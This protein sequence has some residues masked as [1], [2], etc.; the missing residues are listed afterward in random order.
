MIR[1][2]FM[3]ICM[4]SGLL[5]PD[6][7]QIMAQDIDCQTVNVD[8]KISGTDS[9]I[10]HRSDILT[11]IPEKVMS[12][13]RAGGRILGDVDGDGK[14]TDKD[15]KAIIEYIIGKIPQPFNIENADMDGN[16]IIDINDVLRLV[17][18]C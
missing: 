16:G 17:I 4:L 7:I 15:V 9:L 6:N 1:Q 13:T 12:D 8:K 18:R 14:C 2:L 5:C 11:H 3:F 10:F